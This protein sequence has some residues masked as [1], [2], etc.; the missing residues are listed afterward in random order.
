MHADLL[1]HVVDAS[2]P[3]RDAHIAAVNT[4]LG[5]IG[6]QAIPQVLVMNKIDLT[7]FPARVE[8]D[9]Y[10]KI[11]R[12]WTSAETGAGLD[13]VRAALEEHASA[14]LPLPR[15]ERSAAA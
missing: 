2:S 6:A 3:D 14:A 15:I 7:P 8:R 9:E 13:S 12:I 4:V 5:E 10:G 11:A 1:L